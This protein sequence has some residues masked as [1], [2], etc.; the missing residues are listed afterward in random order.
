M[1]Q[2]KKSYWYAVYTMP[3][4]EKKVNDALQQKGIV[5]YCPLQKVQRQWA[6]RKKY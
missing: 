6:D 1:I 2:E 3:N 5:S 4:F